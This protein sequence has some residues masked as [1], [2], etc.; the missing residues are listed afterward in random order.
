MNQFFQYLKSFLVSNAKTAGTYYLYFTN[1]FPVC[2][3]YYNNNDPVKGYTLSYYHRAY[4]SCSSQREISI[5]IYSKL[6]EGNK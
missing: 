4:Q 5:S 6:P 3:C 2:N 1:S